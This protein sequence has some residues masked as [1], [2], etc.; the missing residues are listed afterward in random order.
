M[1]NRVNCVMYYGTEGVIKCNYCKIVM[2]V[3]VI[4]TLFFSERKRLMLLLLPKRWWI[5][6]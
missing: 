5:L 2:A 4:T 1:R 3:G 6:G